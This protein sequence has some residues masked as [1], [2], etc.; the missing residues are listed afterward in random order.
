V[1]DFASVYADAVDVDGVDPRLKERLRA[2][3]EAAVT[4]PGGPARFLPH[5]QALLEFL[6]SPEGRTDA[7][8]RAVDYFF[9]LGDW[10]WGTL[11]EPWESI[12]AD[13]GG[14]LHEAVAAPDIAEVLQAT[15][16]LLLERVRAALPRA[17]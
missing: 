8:C 1:R 17:P 7:N 9:C 4:P 6:A 12:F 5:L 11:P 15:P 13:L 14:G 3:Y 16:E 10:S 2:L